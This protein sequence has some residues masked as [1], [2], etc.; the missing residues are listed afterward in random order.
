LA[1]LGKSAKQIEISIAVMTVARTKA[2]GTAK[3]ALAR[4]AAVYVKL[5]EELLE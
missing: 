4:P 3:P 1:L 5:Q 2:P